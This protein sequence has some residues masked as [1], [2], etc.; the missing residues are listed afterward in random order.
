MQALR[1]AFGQALVE[2]ATDNEFLVVD[3]DVKG[4][5][6]VHH[7]AKAWPDRLIQVGIAEQNAMGVAAGLNISTGLPIFVTGFATFLMRGW[8][9]A[10]LSI[11]YGNR[12]VKIVASH[13]G[14]D[15]GPD[16][17][18]N[19]C[20]EDFACWRTLPNFVVISPSSP[21][22]MRA[23]TKTVLEYKGPVY[24][25]SSRS[26]WNEMPFE[27][28]FR[29]GKS[30]MLREGND[31]AIIATGKM[32]WYALKAAELLYLS[33]GI[34]ARIIDMSTLKPVDHSAILSY[35][36]EVKFI[37]TYEDHG[38]YGGLGDAVGNSVLQ[39]RYPIPILPICVEGHGRS[40]DPDDLMRVY[41]IT[42][43]D[44][45]REVIWEWEHL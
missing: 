5:T 39:T 34:H 30:Y 45:C 22:Q 18:S 38:K 3:C 7:F 15:T 32:V 27:E 36:N 14:L 44:V 23:A 42:P 12:N 16:G 21:A 28:E 40:G 29:I 17:A 37:V 31:I 11:D 6:G 13:G 24:M 43:E 2:L 35:C 33:R 20:L 9:V 19:Q 4:G 1:E 41:H 26:P 8:E 10:R 25:R